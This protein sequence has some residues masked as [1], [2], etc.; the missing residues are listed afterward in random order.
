MWGLG[1]QACVSLPSPCL[2][3]PVSDPTVTELLCPPSRHNGRNFPLETESQCKPGQILSCFWEV[4][5]LRNQQVTNTVA[6]LLFHDV[7]DSA[8]K[9][10]LGGAGR[11][12]SPKG[13]KH[14]AS[15]HLS[16]DALRGKNQKQSRV[17]SHARLRKK[18]TS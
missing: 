13:R 2:L 8:K 7:T 11:W 18:Q 6:I 9:G 14:V 16:L 1:P 3:S 15:S 17:P 4:L 10:N 12:C 5:G